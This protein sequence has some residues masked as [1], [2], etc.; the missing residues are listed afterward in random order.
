MCRLVAR[1]QGDESVPVKLS[2]GFYLPITLLIGQPFMVMSQLG[3]YSQ[4]LFLL[5]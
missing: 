1:Q 5:C 3:I 2:F 4:V